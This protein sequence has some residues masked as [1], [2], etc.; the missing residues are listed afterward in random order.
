[1]YKGIGWYL[2]NGE[3][4]SQFHQRILKVIRLEYFDEDFQ[5]LLNKK[6]TLQSL[7][8]KLEKIRKNTSEYS[9]KLSKK[10]IESIINW[11]SATDYKALKELSNK[12]LIKKSYLNE[13]YLYDI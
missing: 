13:C 3:F 7:N 6:P 5:D 10:G 1:M 8:N 9:K 4:V 2:N 11:Y 12:N